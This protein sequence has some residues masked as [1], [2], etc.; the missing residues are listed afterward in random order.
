MRLQY[1][2]VDMKDVDPNLTALKIY[3]E[4]YANH[5]LQK[6]KADAGIRGKLKFA[7]TPPLDG[8]TVKDD[9]MI[10]GEMAK[11]ARVHVGGLLLLVRCCRPGMSFAVCFLAR[12]VARWT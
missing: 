10:D 4:D 5:L 12:Q 2:W 7:P 3:Q 1:R 6:Y 8:A 9:E 11:T